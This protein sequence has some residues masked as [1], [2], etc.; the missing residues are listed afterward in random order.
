[1]IKGAIVYR[2]IVDVQD[3]RGKTN[4]TTINLAMV[5]TCALNGDVLAC[6]YSGDDSHSLLS[7]VL[8][9]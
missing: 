4:Q 5:S 2:L 6:K 3:K 8:E 7:L 1:M 9:P